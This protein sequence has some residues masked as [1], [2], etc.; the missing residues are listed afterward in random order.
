[1]LIVGGDSTAMVPDVPV[2]EDVTVS[3]AVIVWFPGVFKV[4]ENVCTPLSR[5]A[6]DVN[7]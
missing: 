6:P 5:P 3:V 2:I 7:M 1:L 4:A